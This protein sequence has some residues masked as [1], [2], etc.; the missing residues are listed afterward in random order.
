MQRLLATTA[1]LLL[2]SCGKKTEETK[3]EPPAPT[4]EAVQQAPPKSGTGMGIVTDI[5]P[6]RKFITLDHNDIPMIMDAMAMEYPVENPELLKGIK[7]NDSVDFT[8]VKT[9][10]SQ[11]VVTV[12]RKK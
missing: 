12:I 9:P 3:T 8:L 11:Y 4:Q 6:D 10:E 2:V 5:S 7:K 1:L